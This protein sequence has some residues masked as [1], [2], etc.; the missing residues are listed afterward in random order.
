MFNLNFKFNNHNSNNKDIKNRQTLI[1]LYNN[2]NHKYKQY[3]KIIIIKTKVKN[4]LK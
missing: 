1:Q 4:N 2:N 3:L